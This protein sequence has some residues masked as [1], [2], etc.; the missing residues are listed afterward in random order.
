[1]LHQRENRPFKPTILHMMLECGDPPFIPSIKSLYIIKNS[2]SSNVEAFELHN[3][4]KKCITSTVFNMRTR[5]K[6]SMCWPT[7]H[8][9]KIGGTC[10]A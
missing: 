6:Q 4:F 10:F 9:L 3:D 1:M 2:R 7:R 5:D 8:K